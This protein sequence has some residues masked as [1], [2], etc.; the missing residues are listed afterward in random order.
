MANPIYGDRS[1]PKTLLMTCVW[2]AVDFANGELKE[3]TFPIL[4]AFAESK[5]SGGF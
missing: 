2:H 5:F 4:F 3:E 1:H